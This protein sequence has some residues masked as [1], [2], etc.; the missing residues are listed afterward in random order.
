MIDDAVLLQ[1]VRRDEIL[2]QSVVPSGLPEPPTL[3]DQIVVTPSELTCSEYF[4]AIQFQL[5]DTAPDLTNLGCWLTHVQ[6][7]DCPGTP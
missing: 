7:I 4:S 6:E 2:L 5:S 3:E 1:H